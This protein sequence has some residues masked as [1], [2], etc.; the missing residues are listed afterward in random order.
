MKQKQRIGGSKSG[1]A[2]D[3]DLAAANWRAENR[4]AIEAT[5]RWVEE[6]G[7][8]PERYRMF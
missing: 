2:K 5:N 6:H 3:R 1:N 8:P 7:L 4:A